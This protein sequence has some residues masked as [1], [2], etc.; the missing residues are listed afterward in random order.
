MLTVWGFWQV[1]PEKLL[2]CD[3]LKK[4]LEFPK[5]KALKKVSSAACCPFTDKPSAQVTQ[6]RAAS[7]V[8]AVEP[9]VSPA[10]GAWELAG[11]PEKSHPCGS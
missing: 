8:P 11:A 5:L 6:E 4:P 3:S 10:A 7:A 1:L 9:M 2:L